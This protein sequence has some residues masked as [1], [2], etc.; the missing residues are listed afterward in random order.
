MDD[1]P[2][3]GDFDRPAVRGKPFAKGNS[4]RR[5]GSKNR[6][7]A[8]G[9]VFVEG[10]ALELVRKGLELAKSGDS[11]LL[12]F[13]LDRLVAKERPITIDLS[14]SDGECD[15]VEVSQSIFEAAARGQIT[16]S[17]ALSLTEI[18]EAHARI[19]K[20]IEFGERL[21]Q[22]EKTLRDLQKLN[23]EKPR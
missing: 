13:F 17:E 12:K 9:Q 4:G 10:E 6:A 2:N 8:L 7:T 1:L 5:P 11:I 3:H 23:P 20:F 15:P 22:I 19:M 21:D 16:P 14:L 18:I